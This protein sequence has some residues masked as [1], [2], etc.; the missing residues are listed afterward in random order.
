[1]DG[2]KPAEVTGITCDGIVETTVNESSNIEVIN[3]IPLTPEI[4]EKNGFENDFYEEETIADNGVKI[5]L[6]GY[7]YREDNV[8]VS[9]CDGGVNVCNDFTDADIHIRCESVHQLQHALRLAGIDKAI[10]F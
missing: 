10:I 7:S 5:K 1:M 3:P 2:I 8:S 4:L 9:Y 6:E